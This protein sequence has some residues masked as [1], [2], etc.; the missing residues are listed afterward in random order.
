MFKIALQ[1]KQ[2]A[3][4]V[5]ELRLPPWMRI[6][7]LL[8]ALFILISMIYFPIENGAR[9]TDYFPMLFIIMA[10]FVA[11]YEERWVFNTAEKTVEKRFGLIFYY[12]KDV[13]DF[14]DIKHIEIS[15]VRKGNKNKNSSKYLK[16]TLVLNNDT[17]KDMELVYFREKEKFMRNAEIISGFC[18]LPLKK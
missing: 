4:D 10:F 5:M 15:E 11:V 7:F 13:S 3:K 18:R 6:M 9:G 1:I 17:E 14:S 8:F 2:T 16:M 12:S